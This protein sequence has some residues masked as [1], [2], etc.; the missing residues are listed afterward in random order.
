MI[1]D[2]ATATLG[3]CLSDFR[4]R[5]NDNARVK[6]LIVGWN[7][8][9]LVKPLD[10]P[11]AYTMTIANLEMTGVTP[12]INGDGDTVHLQANEE[13]LKR[14]FTGDYKPAAALADGNMELFSTPRDREKLEALSM[15]IW[16][17]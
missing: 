16:G 11:T 2:I 12:G 15:V 8:D 4:E 13:I 7:R 5:F 1:H 14:I 17:L 9:V 6:R 10:A 3:E